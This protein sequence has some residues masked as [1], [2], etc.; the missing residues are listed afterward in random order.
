MPTSAAS[1]TLPD[2]TA[3]V[4]TVAAAPHIRAALVERQRA[5]AAA[6]PVVMA[7]RDIGTVVLPDAR[8][9]FFLTASLPERAKRRTLELAAGGI[10]AS[11]SDVAAAACRTRPAR[12]G[13][14]DVAAAGGRRRGLRSIRPTSTSTECSSGC[15]PKCAAGDAFLPVR[16]CVLPDRV[17]RA[18]ALRATG[19]ENLPRTGPVIVAC[20]HVSYLDP[21]ALGIGLPRMVTYLAK[22][23][24]FSIP[25][26]GALVRGCGAYPLDRDAGGVAAVRAA[27]RVLKNGRCIGIFPEGTRNLH[28]TRHPRKAARRS[29]RRSRARRWCRRR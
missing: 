26:L 23:E 11:G 17:H 21:V 16:T 7:G 2:V 9:K 3:A 19:A 15:S 4:S 22:K 20:N 5:I 8:Y 25:I 13:A 10:D 28:R 6:E 24:L 1:S 14:G 27:L 12:Y 18:V 29:W